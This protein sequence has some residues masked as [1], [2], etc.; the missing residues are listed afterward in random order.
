MWCTIIYTYT[1]T[2]QLARVVTLRMG[3]TYKLLDALPGL[4]FVE[5]DEIRIVTINESAF[6]R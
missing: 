2:Q 4:N 3:A 1:A 5:R 6:F